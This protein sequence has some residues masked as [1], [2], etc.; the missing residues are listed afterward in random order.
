MPALVYDRKLAAAGDEQVNPD[1]PRITFNDFWITYPRRQARKEAEKAWKQIDGDRH[2]E[3]LAAIM[4]AKKTH[5]W[6]RDSG[7]YI[8]MPATYLRGERWSDELE[9]D[10]TMGQCVWN[11]HGNRG[12]E[13]R[14]TES[15]CVE[16]RGV[17]YCKKHGDRVS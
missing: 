5:Q 12:D 17:C 10:I 15:A 6:R 9:G 8:P 13:P 2:P 4:R 16:K 14:C 7:Q 1:A 11:I 3:M